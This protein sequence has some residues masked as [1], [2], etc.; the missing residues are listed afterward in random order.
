[1]WEGRVVFSELTEEISPIMKVDAL[2][3][4]KCCISIYTYSKII[5]DDFSY[6]VKYLLITQSES[7]VCSLT[8]FCIHRLMSSVW[9]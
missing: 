9:L 2:I 4:W 5:A 8:F 6:L 1:M 3:L 7:K